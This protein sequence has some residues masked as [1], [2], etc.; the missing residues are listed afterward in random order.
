MGTSVYLILRDVQ[1]RSAAVLARRGGTV[2]LAEG[3]DS[4]SVHDAVA[5][6]VEAGPGKSVSELLRDA[7]KSLGRG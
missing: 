3:A 5:A 1:P 6:A 4:A 2:A 7:L